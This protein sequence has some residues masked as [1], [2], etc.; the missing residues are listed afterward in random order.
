MTVYRD[1]FAKYDISRYVDIYYNPGDAAA[2]LGEKLSMLGLR[3][4]TLALNLDGYYYTWANFSWNDLYSHWLSAD[5]N[6][7]SLN[8]MASKNP[9]KWIT[10]KHRASHFL[11]ETEL[12]GGVIYLPNENGSHI[13]FG[14]VY[15][16]PLSNRVKIE[17]E[18][19][20]RASTAVVR[21]HPTWVISARKKP[22]TARVF[23]AALILLLNG[24][25]SNVDETI[26]DDVEKNMG[27]LDFSHSIAYLRE[28]GLMPDWLYTRQKG[29]GTLP[30]VEGLYWKTAFKDSLT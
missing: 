7:S 11:G 2:K 14:G 6:K 18:E 3:H 24:S 1:A 9:G 23:V 10:G 5:G 16:E 12:F 19:L 21:S 22:V 17:I 27:T 30:Y 8:S 29:N 26:L 28:S 25:G 4:Y 20:A 13:R 15:A